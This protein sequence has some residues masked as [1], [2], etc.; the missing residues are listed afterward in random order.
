MTEFPQEGP[1]LT[2]VAAHAKQDSVDN[3]LFMPPANP[4]SDW[5]TPSI[6]SLALDLLGIG[7]A[8]TVVGWFCTLPIVGYVVY[9]FLMTPI[10]VGLIALGS[11]L[12]MVYWRGITRAWLEFAFQVLAMHSLVLGFCKLWF[13][14][15]PK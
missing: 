6:F 11:F 14:N 8:W 2:D 9:F 10:T 5:V 12:Y 1:S 3:Y 13:S 7:A 4:W 15:F